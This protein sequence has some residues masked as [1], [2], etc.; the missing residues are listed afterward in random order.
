MN[1]DADKNETKKSQPQMQ[2]TIITLLLLV[3][4][5]RILRLLD[6]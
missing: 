3:R 5:L 2:L 1:R 6:Y 4:S